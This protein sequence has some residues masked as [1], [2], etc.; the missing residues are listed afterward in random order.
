ML[1]VEKFLLLNT[2]FN[3]YGVFTLGLGAECM[4]NAFCV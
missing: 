3:Q 2:D 4:A 1:L